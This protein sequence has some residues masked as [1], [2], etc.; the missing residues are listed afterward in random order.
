[1]TLQGITFEKARLATNCSLKM[2]ICNLASCLC[3]WEKYPPGGAIITLSTRR[4]HF[5]T[6]CQGVPSPDGRIFAYEAIVRTVTGRIRLGKFRHI[7]S[8]W[9]DVSYNFTFDWYRKWSHVRYVRTAC[10][11]SVTAL[12]TLVQQLSGDLSAPALLKLTFYSDSHQLQCMKLQH[13][14]LDIFNSI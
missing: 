12:V 7:R 2:T 5:T 1:M 3:T 6:I 8:Y 14:K 13:F 11:P 4:C 10:G 9:L